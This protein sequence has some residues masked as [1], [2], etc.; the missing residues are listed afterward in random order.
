MGITRHTQSPSMSPC[1]DATP[2]DMADGKQGTSRTAATRSEQM[3]QGIS[4]GREMLG[5]WPTNPSHA[6]SPLQQLA[7]GDMEPHLGIPLKPG[8]VAGCQGGPEPSC[9]TILSLTEGLAVLEGAT[10]DSTAARVSVWHSHAIDLTPFSSA[11][12]CFDPSPRHLSPSQ[13]PPSGWGTP[14]AHGSG[15]TAPGAAPL[16]PTAP[17]TGRRFPM[18][19]TVGEE[20][21][22]EEGASTFDQMQAQ[23]VAAVGGRVLFER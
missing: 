20:E 22:A 1:G 3:M 8:C 16:P 13:H 6:A 14:D 12:L 9:G 21:G 4:V 18:L 23:G 10:P 19:A 17:G 5:V 7:A 2:S 11:S 15:S